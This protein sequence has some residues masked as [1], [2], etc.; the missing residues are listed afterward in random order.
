MK[1]LSNSPHVKNQAVAN[2]QAK[3]IP[4]FKIYKNSI[5]RYEKPQ[6][7]LPLVT[8]GATRGVKHNLLTQPRSGLNMSSQSIKPHTSHTCITKQ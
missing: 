5:T 1:I 7:G 8:T 3:K 2:M 6:R 4:K